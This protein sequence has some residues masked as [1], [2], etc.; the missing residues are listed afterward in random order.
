MVD[1]FI[2][3][4]TLHNFLEPSCGDGVFIDAALERGLI[5]DG[6]QLTAV[7]TETSEVQKIIGRIGNCEK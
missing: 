5:S 4:K 6:E 7:E 3:D 2:K 1:F